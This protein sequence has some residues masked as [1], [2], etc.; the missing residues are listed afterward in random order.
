VVTIPLM[1]TVGVK[2]LK[3]R[4]S[5]YL[6]LVKSGEAV[7]VTERDVVVAE[8]RPANLQNR[9]PA[10][11]REQLE[12]LAERGN[13]TVRSESIQAWSGPNGKLRFKGFSTQSLLDAKREDSR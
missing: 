11:L 8:L 2:T 7:L 1:K 3:A 13:A 6:R 5:E 12:D 4:L 10:D 9:A